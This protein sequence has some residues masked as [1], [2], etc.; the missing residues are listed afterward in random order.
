MP[1]LRLTTATLGSELY[2]SAKALRDE[3]LSS[4]DLSADFM[5]AGVRDTV[6]AVLQLLSVAT[7]LRRRPAPLA[8]PVFSPLDIAR[9]CLARAEQF[10]DA[11]GG[12]TAQ[13]NVEAARDQAAAARAAT[14]AAFYA[15]QGECRARWVGDALL[16]ASATDAGTVYAVGVGGCL[17][18]AATNHRPC[19]HAELRAGHERAAEIWLAN[20]DRMA[21]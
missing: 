2:A 7:V 9:A 16:V 17:C 21:A 1:T 13:G 19:W 6:I 10:R 20:A 3:L 5:G 14:K 8:A 15:G 12:L 4:R 11:A 18:Q